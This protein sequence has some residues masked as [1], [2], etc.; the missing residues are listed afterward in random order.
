M[1][2]ALK[3]VGVA[4]RE[5]DVDHD[6]ATEPLRTDR[7]AL[8]FNDHEPRLRRALV[9]AYGA[10]RGAEAAREALAWAW[11]HFDRVESMAN[12]GGYLW[13]VG[14]THA[15]R[16]GR[17]RTWVL[18]DHREADH[19][20]MFEPALAEALGALPERQRVAVLLVHSYGYSLSEAAE[21]LGCRI[22]TLRHHLDR[23]MAKLRLRLGVNDA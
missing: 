16:A 6:Q 9:A 2:R 8:L 10:E 3:S 13:R 17:P 5:D 14:Q 1:A 11:E 21:Q 23:G 12:P 22:R 19:E 4:V 7:F 20:R 18:E 15:H